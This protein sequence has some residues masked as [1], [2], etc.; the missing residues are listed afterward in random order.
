MLVEDLKVL[1]EQQCDI[2]P[3]WQRL[4][5]AGNQLEDGRTLSSYEITKGCIVHFVLK[6]RGGNPEGLVQLVSAL[7]HVPNP[8]EPIRVQI[9]GP[10]GREEYEVGRPYVVNSLMGMIHTRQGIPLDRQILLYGG[11]KL[12][13][14]ST[15]ED[16]HY[17]DRS[18]D[19]SCCKARKTST[20]WNEDLALDY[21]PGL[22]T[23]RGHQ[24]SGNTHKPRRSPYGSTSTI[25]P[26]ITQDRTGHW[27][28]ESILG[29]HQREV[30]PQ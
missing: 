13:E 22:Y 9:L 20:I 26:N 11:A 24:Y 17:I 14:F 7:I 18:R 6:L 5:F 16:I 3:N 29:T 4:I 21:T 15:F 1:V 19:Y 23:W 8:H 25:L 12:Q 30:I 28:S 2:P 10:R 27:Y